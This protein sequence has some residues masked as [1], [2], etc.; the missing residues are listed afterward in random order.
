MQQVFVGDKSNQFIGCLRESAVVLATEQQLNGL[1]MFCTLA[2]H[3]T[4][5]TRLLGDFDVTVIT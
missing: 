4:I 3:L 2:T 1:V 5:V